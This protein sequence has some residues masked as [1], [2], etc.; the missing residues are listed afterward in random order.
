MRNTSWKWQRYLEEAIWTSISI[1]LREVRCRINA[2]RSWYLKIR[3]SNLCKKQIK[4]NFQLSKHQLHDDR[5][6]YKLPTALQ[7]IPWTTYILENVSPSSI[8][9]TL[10]VNYLVHNSRPLVPVFSQTTEAQAKT[11]NLRSTLILFSH[12]RLCVPSGIFPLS[13]GKYR[14]ISYI[15]MHKINTHIR[16]TYR[17]ETLSLSLSEVST[18][19]LSFFLTKK[20]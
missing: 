16:M 13:Y 17:R 1:R 14:V 8:Q 12:L 7:V 4:W 2:K 19:S 6:R 15:M 3:Q 11:T 5:Y 18:I 9:E 10:M 20:T